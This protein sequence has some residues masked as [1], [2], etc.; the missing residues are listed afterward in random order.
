MSSLS[1]AREE[2]RQALVRFLASSLRE[3]TDCPFLRAW[4]VAYHRSEIL[5][6]WME[7]FIKRMARL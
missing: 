6:R 3:A 7:E 2:V 4:S 5:K 1:V